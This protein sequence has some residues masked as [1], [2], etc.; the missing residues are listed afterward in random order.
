METTIKNFATAATKVHAS[1]TLGDLL[2][3]RTGVINSETRTAKRGFMDVMVSILNGEGQPYSK[4]LK[5]KGP[6]YFPPAGA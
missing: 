2:V 3:T 6:C 5:S 4:M 1:R